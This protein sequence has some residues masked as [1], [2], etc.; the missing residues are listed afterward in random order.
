[1]TD[2]DVPAA[3]DGPAEFGDPAGSLADLAPEAHPK[4]TAGKRSAASAVRK[5]LQRP[6]VPTNPHVRLLDLIEQD[7]DAEMIVWS[8]LDQ[9]GFQQPGDTFRDSLAGL[10][11]YLG[12]RPTGRPDQHSLT[13]LSL[14]T[15]AFTTND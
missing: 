2:I 4:G 8:A 7:A 9:C 3:E 15:Q 10:Q 1:M 11:K 14:R 13:W 6:A 12:N 5:A